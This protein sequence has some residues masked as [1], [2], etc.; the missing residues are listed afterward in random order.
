MRCLTK[1][2]TSFSHCAF[3]KLGTRI[4]YCELAFLTLYTEQKREG[5]FTVTDFAKFRG[6]SGLKP[7]SRAT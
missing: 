5:Y 3:S 1:L 7:F 4:E 6:M 2:S